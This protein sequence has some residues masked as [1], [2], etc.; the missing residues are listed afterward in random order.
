MDE[1]KMFLAEMIAS[2]GAI[3][4]CRSDDGKAKIGWA[5]NVERRVRRLQTGNPH[6]DC[7]W[8]PLSPAPGRLRRACM[9]FSRIGVF[10]AS[11]LMTGTMR[12]PNVCASCG[13]VVLRESFTDEIPTITRTFGRR[14]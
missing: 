9:E 14:F 4:C 12:F 2:V 7:L 5:F 11:G 8:S 13:A 6:R 1:R 10:V 3:Y